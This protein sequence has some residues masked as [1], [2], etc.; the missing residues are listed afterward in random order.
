MWSKKDLIAH[1]WEVSRCAC[2]GFFGKFKDAREKAR[3]ETGEVKLNPLQ[4]AETGKKRD[5]QLDKNIHSQ[6]SKSLLY[7]NAP[8]VIP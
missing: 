5:D 4:E 2:S 1:C 8:F 7:D 3:S 6:I